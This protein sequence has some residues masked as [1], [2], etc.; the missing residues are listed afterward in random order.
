LEPEMDISDLSAKNVNVTMNSGDCTLKNITATDLNISND[1][2]KT[3]L[4]GADLKT[5]KIDANSG[6]VL[7]TGVAADY[8]ELYADM[9]KISGKSLTSNGLKVESNSGGID[10]Q[11]KLLGLTDITCD[12]GSVTVNPGAP[13]DQFN[14]ELNADTGSVSVG[15]DSASG[16]ITSNNGSAKNTLKINADMGDIKVNFN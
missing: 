4:D 15:G 13:R 5:L 3:T 12:M 9:G 2:G 1:M 10:L 16:G 11:G 8:G 14:Y 6:E 7:L